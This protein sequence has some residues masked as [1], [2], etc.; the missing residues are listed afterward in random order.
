MRMFNKK[1]QNTAEYAILIALVIAAAIGIQT[2]VKR[3]IQGRVKDGSDSIMNEIEGG[4]W[5]QISNVT[6]TAKKQYEPTELSTQVTSDVLQDDS[7]YTMEK[8]GTTSRDITRRTQQA[9]GDY[10]KIESIK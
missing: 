10:Q 5:A 8:T 3:G 6:V 9:A 4:D 7:T 2:Y 1:G